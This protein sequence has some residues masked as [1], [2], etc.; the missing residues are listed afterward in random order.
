M[1][2]HSDFEEEV[3]SRS[4]RLRFD[5]NMPFVG[6]KS[7]NPD[8]NE[9]WLSITFNS[10]M[11]KITSYHKERFLTYEEYERVYEAEIEVQ[12]EFDTC[13]YFYQKELVLEMMWEKKEGVKVAILTPYDK[14]IIEEDGIFLKQNRKVAVDK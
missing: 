12:K 9:A 1:P 7:P 14:Y 2:E 11:H 6:L 13:S 8:L 10:I 3:L 5:G 4:S